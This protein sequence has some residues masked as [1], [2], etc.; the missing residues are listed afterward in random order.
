MD[1]KAAL[2]EARE[3]LDAVGIPDPARRLKEYPHQLSGGMRQRA[4]IA[5]ALACKPR[6]LIADEPTTALDVTI[7]AQILTL[8]KQLVDETGTAL[9]MITHDLGVVA[10]LC[11]TV[12]VLY[13]G[14]IVERA[15]PARAVRPAAAPVHARAA[16]LGARGSTRR[17]ASGCTPSVARWPTTSRG[18][19][20]ARSR[21]AATTWWTPASDGTPAAGADRRRR[22]RCAATTPSPRRW[23]SRDRVDRADR[24]PLRRTARRRR[25]TSR[26]RAACSSTGPSGTST[27]STGSRCR[28][29]RARRT[30]WWASRAAA[31]PR[32]AG[33]CCG[34]SSR[35]TARSS[36]TAPTSRALK[37]EP[38]R[39]IRRRIQMIF[40]DPLSSLDPRQSVE[41]LLVEGLKAHGLAE[42]QGGRRQAAA[43]SRWTRSACPRRRCSKYPHE[44]S[45]GQRQ[46]IGIA[47]ALVLEPGPD[48]RRRAGVRAGRVDP[49]PGAQPAGR[50]AG[51]A[52]PDVPDHRARPGGGPAHRRHGR[53]DVPG[54]SGRGGVQ[55]RPLPG[56]DAPVHPGAACRRCRCPTRRWR[57]G[58]SG[59]CSP[60]TCPRRPNPP[61]GCRFHTRCPWAQPTR[62]AD[63][64]PGA[65]R[66]ASTGTGWPATS[67]RT[68][69]PAGS[70]RTRWSRSWSGR[71]TARRRATPVS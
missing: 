45:G 4:L 32:W 46:R 29:T 34:W 13:G 5:I 36:S 62:C 71:T 15:A 44:F 69:R 18:P 50:P 33:A 12:N 63:E 59:S 61:A 40:Q 48:R 16:Q 51:R 22:R 31:S 64:R 27:P 65:A 66:G 17:A 6:L 9:I 55:R 7:Q 20:A 10:G 60:A 58:G 2:R 8:L 14:K 70:G 11:D 28:S 25:C 37:G 35:P 39:R 49:G 38:M 3:L 42:G 30:G 47:R 24:R 19:R 43:A 1:R 68:S 41:S 21:R 53:G 67:P 54:R 56:A 52:R 57:T 26:S 23:R